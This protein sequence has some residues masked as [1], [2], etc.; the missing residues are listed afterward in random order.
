MV[1]PEE[2]NGWFLHAFRCLKST[3]L[4]LDSQGESPNLDQ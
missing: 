4:K 1:V 3:W 2:E